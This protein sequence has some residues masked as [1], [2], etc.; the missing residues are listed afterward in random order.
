ML[1]KISSLSFWIGKRGL[2]N[3]TNQIYYED[4]LLHA[5][6]YKQRQVEIGNKL[7]KN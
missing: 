3:P 6:F 2:E 4:T 5:F 1:E 7:R